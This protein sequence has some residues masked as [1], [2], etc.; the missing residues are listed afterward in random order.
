[1]L[2]VCVCLKE[3]KY[4]IKKN[5]NIELSLLEFPGVDVHTSS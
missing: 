4:E 1:M 3:L 2:T 5:W